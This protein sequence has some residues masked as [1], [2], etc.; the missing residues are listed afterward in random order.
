LID[1]ICFFLFG[2]AR[3]AAKRQTLTYYDSSIV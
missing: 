3:V 2:C 1:M